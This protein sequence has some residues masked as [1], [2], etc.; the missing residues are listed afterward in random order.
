M[1]TQYYD[2]VIVGARVAGSAAALNLASAGARIL[3]VERGSKVGDALSTHAL[4]RPAVELLGRWGLL[5]SLVQAGTPWVR[6]ATFHYGTESISIP[7]R[8]SRLAEGLVAP[9]RWLLDSTLLDAARN[10]GAEI[11]LGTSF[12]NCLRDGRGRVT[13]AIL[14]RPDGG[15]VAVGSELLIG[16]DGRASRVAESVGARTRATSLHRAATVYGYVP[17]ISNEGYRWYFGPRISA[18][19]IPTTQGDSCVF[20]CCPA[21]DMGAHF[22]TDAMSG[23]IRI[24]ASFDRELAAQ[25]GTSDSLRLRRFPGAPG[26]MRERIG[27]GWALVG[28]AAFFRDPA[29]AHGITD[30]LLDVHSLIRSLRD[31]S[32]LVAYQEERDAQA[33]ALFGISQKIASF[34]WDLDTV[35]SLHAELNACLKAELTSLEAHDEASAPSLPAGG[36][37]RE[38]GSVLGGL[39]HGFGGGTQIRLPKIEVDRVARISAPQ[40]DSRKADRIEP[41]G[42]VT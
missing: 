10:A 41:L 13:G 40:L 12:E 5:D 33:A 6:I 32:E 30:A 34:D 9:R 24:I 11:Q 17:G 21:E 37:H 29:T 27:P 39:Q 3:L 16:A 1:A 19:V 42:I 38:P 25:L 35:K 2:A 15:S 23:F 18:G 20:A 14:R 28:D 7:V 22:A 31:N 8:P 36:V 26:H 4:M